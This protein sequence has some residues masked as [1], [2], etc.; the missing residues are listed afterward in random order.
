MN[1]AMEA[2]NMSEACMAIRHVSGKN[3]KKRVRAEGRERELLG[4]GV[5]WLSHIGL[6]V[7]LF[8]QMPSD[9]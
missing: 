4:V 5:L 1:D 3:G 9:F 2:S 7:T 6:N 8:C